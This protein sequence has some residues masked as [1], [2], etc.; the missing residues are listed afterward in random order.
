[1]EHHS[2]FKLYRSRIFQVTEQQETHVL[3]DY[4][5][6]ATNTNSLLLLQSLFQVLSLISNSNNVLERSVNCGLKLV[7]AAVQ[8]IMKSNNS[9]ILQEG[10]QCILEISKNIIP[11]KEKE[12]QLFE[13]FSESCQM[14]L[15]CFDHA[16]DIH[17]QYFQIVQNSFQIFTINYTCKYSI[18]G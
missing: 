15:R 7:I 9:T 12:E 10:L 16:A 8:K 2:L 4:F 3:L 13:I 14:L 5:F 1:M 11:T 18:S 17:Q 6:E